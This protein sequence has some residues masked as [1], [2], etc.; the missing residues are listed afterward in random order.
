MSLVQ[1]F[2]EQ[3]YDLILVMNK[4]HPLL[5]IDLVAGTLYLIIKILKG[6]YI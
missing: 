2:Q 5:E 3:D 6:W 1:Q 4:I